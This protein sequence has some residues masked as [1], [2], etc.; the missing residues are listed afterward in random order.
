[1]RIHP[2]LCRSTL[3]CLATALAPVG[4]PLLY[5]QD[6]QKVEKS[7]HDGKRHKENKKHHRER[8]SHAD[9]G[10][11][12]GSDAGRGARHADAARSS[13]PEH[14]QVV[15]F[16]R[17]PKANALGTIEEARLVQ[18]NAPNIVVLMP[19]SEIEK[20]P[21]FVLGDAM[22]RMPGA[23]IIFK[24]GESRALQVRGLDSSLNGV[25]FEDVLLPAGSMSGSGRAMPLDAMPASLA[26]ALELTKTN[27]PEQD[28]IALGGQM[29]I[30]S[31]DIG[32]NQD[33]FLKFHLAG[34]YRD[35]S[36]TPVFQGTLAGGMR[37]G[38]HGDP[39]NPHASGDR[40]FSVSFFLNGLTDWL[41]MGDLQQKFASGDPVGSQANKVTQASQVMYAGHKVRY[42][43]GGTLGWDIDHNNKIYLKM[44]ESAIYAPVVRNQ[45]IYAFSPKTGLGDPGQDGTA[46]LTQG[47]TNTKTTDLE[48]VYKFG[49]DSR[50]GRFKLDYF[51]AWAANNVDQTSSYVSNFTGPTNVPV[52][53]DNVTNPLRPTVT[54]LNGVN[55]LNYNAYKLSSLSNQIQHDKDYEWTGHVG[56]STELNLFRELK[57]MLSFGGGLRMA[58]IQHYDPTYTYSHLPNVTAG[59]LAGSDQWTFF[60]GLYNIGYPAGPHQVNQL[61]SSA[62]YPQ[63]TSSAGTTA[64]QQYINDNENVYN[65]YLQYRATWRRLGILAGFRYEKTDGVYRGTQTVTQGGVTTLSPRAVGQE[66]ANFFPTVQLRYN[67]TD[68]LIAR[69]N[70]STAVGRPGFNQVT[71]SQTVNTST[72][73][74]SIGNPGLKPTTGNNFDV[75]MEYYLPHGGIISGGAFYKLFKNYVVNYTNYC[76]GCYNLP[77]QATVSTYANIPDAYARGFELNYRQQF[78]FLPGLLKGFGVGGNMTYVNS[79]GQQRNGTQETL[80]NTTSHIWNFE[81]FYNYGPVSVQFN[82]NY[83]G[84]TMTGLG[85]D[86][87]LDSYVQPFLN[88]DIGASYRINRRVSV[89]FQARNF[90]NTMQNATQGI[91]AKRMVELQ[92]F[93]S[94][95]MFGVDV[96]L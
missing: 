29:N 8:A 69:A 12:H 62:I 89:N 92:Y 71:A 81:A 30:L 22:R 34:G 25:M 58:H 43:Y 65:T 44:F 19:Q 46:S 33:P 32:E 51:G 55:P 16:K 17:P 78:E 6:V 50:I 94:A 68:N 9:V 63:V 82:G 64:Q 67:I 3:L 72:N 37:F 86:P 23:S 56:A 66:Y 27:R 2:M 96:S 42:S 60:D 88:F 59:Q 84:L 91:S 24:S 52:S 1:M 79:R 90:T 41:N 18:K 13:A 49:G 57:G 93:G 95:Y 53:Y 15:G 11:S 26:G 39:F 83:Q 40:P 21:N 73:A 5:A 47:V 48:R 45:L 54:V 70:W 87:S 10:R 76:T 77:G 35:P 61:A 74:V 20:I 4:A 28:A 75:S 80:P 85:S 7:H 38:L 31:R 36:A 14:L